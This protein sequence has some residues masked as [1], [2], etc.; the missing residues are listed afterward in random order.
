M[1]VILR[2]NTKHF[3]FSKLGVQFP[4]T[5]IAICIQKLSGIARAFRADPE[6]QNEEENGENLRQNERNYT[7]MRKK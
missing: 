1:L 6:D 5:F 4:H 7:K 2:E 3:F